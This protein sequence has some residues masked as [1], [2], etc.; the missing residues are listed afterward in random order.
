M[1][2]NTPHLLRKVWRGDVYMHTAFWAVW[3]VPLAAMS[4][5]DISLGGWIDIILIPFLVLTTV[6]AWRSTES[7][8]GALWPASLYRLALF[9]FGL[10]MVAGMILLAYGLIANAF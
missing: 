1:K 8:P 4:L 10:L 3:F 5:L 7:P 2:E 6:C 9:A